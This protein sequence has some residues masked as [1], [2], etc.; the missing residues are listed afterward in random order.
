MKLK[1]KSL[2]GLASAGLVA[3]G[4]L[5]ASGAAQADHAINIRIASGHPPTV[6][7][8]GLMKNFF[9]TE[10]KKAVESKT[11]HKVNFIEGYSGSI[12]K[13]FDTF[14]GVQNGVVDIGGFC[15]CFEASKLPMHA[16]QIMLP[17]G[18]MDPVQS[19]G[20]AAEIYEQFPSLAERFQ[21]FDQT[22]LAI[23][24]DGGY[25][26]GTNFEWKT[27]DDLKGHKILGAGLNLNWMSQ[28]GV[29]IVPV[30]DGLPGWYQK[31]KTGVAEGGIMFPS[32][33]G[34][35]FKLHEVGKFYTTI[36]FGSITWHGLV[37][38]NR[39][40]AGLP[41]DVKPVVQEVAGRFQTLT[42]SAN[43]VGYEK[44]M[45]WLKANIT[46]SELPAD[47]R[48]GWAKGLSAWPQQHADALEKDGFPAKKVL[49]AYL[50]AA[51]KQGYTW[52]VRYVVK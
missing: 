35:V 27:L 36:G 24:G 44:D 11:S 29:G 33:W 20:A 32:A 13:V 47:V 50:D 23:I 19:V 21:G 3:G 40:W 7:Y 28:A 18:T 26:L 46:V 1:L 4:M 15:Y 37:V 5:A 14:E 48:L 45:A 8:A 31:I 9:Q 10:L 22:L 39:F 25:N 41:A 52:P 2:I 43:K 6:V 17:F 30:T 42:G 38:N 34:P 12:V 16:F 49:N 51:E